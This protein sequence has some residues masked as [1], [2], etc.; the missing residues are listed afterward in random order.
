MLEPGI[1]EQLINQAI[2]GEI[3]NLGKVHYKESQGSSPMNIIW[4]LE[5]P[6]PVKFLKKTNKLLFS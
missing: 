5:T 6:I 2:R 3:A 1:Y 4:E